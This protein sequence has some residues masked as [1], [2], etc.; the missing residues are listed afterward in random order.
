MKSIQTTPRIYLALA[1][2]LLLLAGSLF[3]TGC[4]DGGDNNS[5]N[6]GHSHH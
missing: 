3:L 1:S 6:A 4:G 2:L 5:N